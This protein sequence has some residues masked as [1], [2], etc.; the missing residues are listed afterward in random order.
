MTVKTDQNRRAFFRKGG[1]AM[2]AALASTTVG[3]TGMMNDQG[4]LRE[5][6][7][8]LED[9]DAI[10]TLWQHYGQLLSEGRFD[11]IPALF[12]EDAEI[13]LDNTTY[14]GRE[15][16][17]RQLFNGSAN[18]GL[19]LSRLLQDGSQE[20]RVD[21][22]PDHRSATACFHAMVKA[23]RQLSGDATIH[24][25]ARLQGMDQEQWWESAR[26]EFE[27][28]KHDG[29]WE[30]HRLQYSSDKQLI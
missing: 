1:M 12:A 6:L 24:Q 3:A 28:V 14:S 22:A 30:I 26:H 2:G 8:G 25:M 13:V 11:E 19:K 4:N 20:E 17:I 10:R 15:Q 23:G 29:F 9:V 18:T 27:L 21:I 16:E 7:A 5:R